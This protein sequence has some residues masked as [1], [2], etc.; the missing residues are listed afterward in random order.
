MSSDHFMEPGDTISKAGAENL[1]F[2]F[3]MV[4]NRPI[5]VVTYPAEKKK[6][7]SFSG[8]KTIL[9]TQAHKEEKLYVA[10][11][12]RLWAY[13]LTPAKDLKSVILGRVKK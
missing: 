4:R 10:R 8:L 1:G 7:D 11:D 5:V 6:H 12:G 13:I 2:R 9:V 3:R